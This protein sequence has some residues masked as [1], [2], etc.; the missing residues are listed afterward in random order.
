MLARNEDSS[1]M[2][3]PV[4]FV[5]FAETCH[6]RPVAEFVAPGLNLLGIVGLAASV[7]V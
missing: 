2:V 3:D 4:I 1:A 7:E 6:P 5:S